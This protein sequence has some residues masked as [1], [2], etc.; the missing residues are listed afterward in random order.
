[1]RR[2]RLPVLPRRSSRAGRPERTLWHAIYCPED[3]SLVIDF[4]LGERDEPADDGR[5]TVRSGY[6]EFK[7]RS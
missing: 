4:Y 3:L 2:G 5:R 6:V 7:L 1:M